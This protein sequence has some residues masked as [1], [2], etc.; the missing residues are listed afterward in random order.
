MNY[1]DQQLMLQHLGPP[2]LSFPPQ[3]F[4]FFQYLSFATRVISGPEA[5]RSCSVH[6]PGRSP[7]FL[8]LPGRPIFIFPCNTN[9]TVR[10]WPL[11]APTSPFVLLSLKCT[12]R[13]PSPRC[14][15]ILFNFL[16]AI[17]EVDICGKSLNTKTVIKTV[18]V[19]RISTN[20]FHRK[21]VDRNFAYSTSRRFDD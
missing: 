7:S 15:S 4:P 8:V 18:D 13:H 19:R 11:N 5:S 9:L 20:C 2:S 17:F 16:F 21:S 3:L 14:M 10:G 1:D 6:S 12:P